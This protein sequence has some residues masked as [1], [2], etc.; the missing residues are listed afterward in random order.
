MCCIP[1]WFRSVYNAQSD[2]THGKQLRSISDLEEQP[3]YTPEAITAMPAWYLN[4]D[5]TLQVIQRLPEPY[6]KYVQSYSENCIGITL[7]PEYFFQ[8]LEN[9]SSDSRI[10]VAS[11]RQLLYSWS[12]PTLDGGR[13]EQGKWY[14]LTD[15]TTLADWEILLEK[16]S[17]ILAEPI[18]RM[19]AVIV[20]IILTCLILIVVISGF[21]AR[22]FMK[23]INLFYGHI[24]EVKN[25]NLQLDDCP[26]E[27]GDLTNSFQEMLDRLNRLI[28]EDYQNKILLREAE[29][30]ALQAQINPHFLYNCLSLINSRALL[31]GQPEISRMSQ[32]LSVFY[33]TTLNKGRSET[34]L[35]N[36]L[37]NVKSYLEIQKLLHEE[38]FDVTW[39]VEPELPEMQL[40]NLILQPLVENA[41]VHG[42][43]PNKPKKGRLFLAVS[44]V[45]DQLRFTIL[46]N[47]AGI[48]AEKLP[49]LLLTDSGGYGLK[50][51]NERLKLT[52]GEDYGLNIQSIQ[53]ESTM[54]TF[55]IPVKE[56]DESIKER[57]G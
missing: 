36:E 50:N 19:S 38:L 55:C 2:L 52:Y 9:V 28:R 49:T 43:L 33:R 15:E 39:Q 35:E 23:R 53:G 32:L 22:L 8:V 41:L 21:W 14:S 37:K 42:I 57:K 17:R 18:S 30:K 29:L 24:Q 47:G 20:L 7:E 34:T 6:E 51:V 25:G 46:D 45:M 31:A 56:A 1:R 11:A 4:A 40:P 54:V 12:A 13:R 26:D 3:W 44:R 48:P 5:G 16:P 10:K 27:I